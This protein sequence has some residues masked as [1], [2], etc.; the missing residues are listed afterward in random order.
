MFVF[1][2][3]ASLLNSRSRQVKKHILLSLF[4]YL[5]SAVYF[6]DRMYYNAI[7]IVLLADD[8]K[9][10]SERGKFSQ[11]IFNELVREKTFRKFINEAI[12]P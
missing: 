4:F 8:E 10:E 12:S 11:K 7:F 5:L 9:R 1:Y 3:T 2:R 6:T